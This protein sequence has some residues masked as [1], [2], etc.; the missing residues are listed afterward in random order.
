MTD[1]PTIKEQN[2]AKKQLPLWAGLLIAVM[3]ASIVTMAA[4]LVVSIMERRG[5][6]SRAL[7]IVTPFT[8]KWIP[9][10]A[11]WRASYPREY[12]SYK[13]M[14][15]TDTET[16]YGGAV[17]RDYLDAD[18]RQVILFA[19]Y[20]F[21]KDYLQARGHT[22]AVDDIKATARIKPGFMAATCWT[23]KSPDVPRMM[24][25]ME[26][27]KFE[28]D[29]SN[30]DS[31]RPMDQTGPEKFYASNWHDLVFDITN[32]IGCQDCHNADTMEL[33]ITRPGLIEAY[34][35][36]HDGKEITEAT[37]QEMRSLVCA[38]CHVEYYFKPEPKNYLK[39]PWDGGTD[40]EA[41]IAYYDGI[42]FADYTHPISKTRIIKA[43]HPDFEMYSTGVHAFRDVS[44][45][46]CHMPYMTE[47]GVKS[48][49]H[50]VQS[51][52]LN[53]ANS[54]AVCHRWGEDEIRTR[55]ESIQTKVFNA[56]I[57]A[58]DALVMAH[59][60]AAA[61]MQAGA[62][63]EELAPIRKL[64]RHAQFRWDYVSANN[65]MGFHSP[66]ESMRVLGD[67][68]NQ[69]Q[70]A[71]LLVARLLA[72]RGI[73]AEPT[74]PDVSTREAAWAAAEAFK[75]GDGIDLLP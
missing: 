40:V 53:I 56:K 28:Y 52:L 65:G 71:R 39:F 63:D 30:W 20:G 12:D 58:E 73:S 1:T 15:I 34:A 69:A 21:S 2:A 11:K 74:Y 64:I 43:Q 14:S 62:S 17:Q 47:G 16:L 33:T 36:L 42:D 75:N 10:S 19:G 5:E 49:D 72:G 37:H 29:L 6:H 7:L 45:A 68:V 70:Q 13:R 50:Q 57:Q 22:Y 8:E 32:P 9:D 23:C 51:P 44:C 35:A 59:F 60:D 25:E 31:P 61:A 66:Q 55:V 54:C 4:L 24:D 3:L 41:M 27:E 46:D 26:P 38:Q 48:S 18:P 67:S